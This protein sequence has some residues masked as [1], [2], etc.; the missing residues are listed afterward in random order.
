MK[1]DFD[2]LPLRS[3]LTAWHNS[4]ATR[5]RFRSAIEKAQ[6]SDSVSNP[7]N[8]PDAVAKKS[9]AE[10][11]EWALSQL[12]EER[13]NLA[14]SRR[15]QELGAALRARLLQLQAQKQA[16]EQAGARK[17]LPSVEPGHGRHRGA[18]RHRC[19]DLVAASSALDF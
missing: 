9:A 6:I 7:I 2:P 1:N 4:E 19:D 14:V 16:T 17:R 15:D 13:K 8:L 18:R 11:C 3:Q 5:R 10:R 12:A